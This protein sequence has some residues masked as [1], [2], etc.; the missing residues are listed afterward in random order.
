M[1]HFLARMVER[2]RGTA[3]RVEPIIA[4]RFVSADSLGG[5]PL[6]EISTEIESAP[7]ARR[8]AEPKAVPQPTEQRAVEQKPQSPSANGRAAEEPEI[9]SATE[10]LL[11][12]QMA[13][14]TDSL[15]VRQ[16]NETREIHD[17]PR[18]ISAVQPEVTKPGSRGNF[19][20]SATRPPATLDGD[21]PVP[22]E[23]R[24][25]APIVRV[26]IGRIEVRAAPAPAQPRPT[27][28]PRGPTLTLEEYQKQRKEGRR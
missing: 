24:G 22:N 13:E 1:T 7:P 15:V 11:L 8:P 27:V 21:L 6:P 26:T 23:P 4:P 17:A 20:R 14:Q 18:K 28:R 3:P 2:A 10:A 9:E 19:R 12:P 5:E 25:Q 16:G